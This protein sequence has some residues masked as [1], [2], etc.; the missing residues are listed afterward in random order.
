M[1]DFEKRA[2]VEEEKQLKYYSVK[3]DNEQTNITEKKLLLN[4][5]IIEIMGNISQT[6]IDILNEL[7]DIQHLTIKEIIII[8]FKDDR[9]IYLGLVAIFISLSLYLIDITGN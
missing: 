6:I 9:M 1:T 7:C 5:S 2:I 4:M 3:A 8:F